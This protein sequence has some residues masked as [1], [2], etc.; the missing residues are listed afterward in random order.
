MVFNVTGVLLGI[1]PSGASR[2]PVHTLSIPRGSHWQIELLVTDEEGTPINLTGR[3]VAIGVKAA[4]GGASLVERAAVL[5]DPLNGICTVYGT[6]TD[7]ESLSVTTYRWD[8]WVDD[9]DGRHQIV[10][11]SNF[12]VL[13]AILLPDEDP[14]PATPLAPMINGF[15][16]DLD[17]LAL[18][19]A[20]RLGPGFELWVVSEGAY[21]QVRV[22]EDFDDA[23]PA[24]NLDGGQWIP[25][26]AGGTDSVVVEVPGEWTQLCETANAEE[27]IDDPRRVDFDNELSASVQELVATLLAY[28]KVTTGTGRIRVRRAGTLGAADG[29]VIADGTLTGTSYAAIAPTAAAFARPSGIQVLQVT[30]SNN[31][32]GAV[33]SLKGIRLGLR[34]E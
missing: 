10:K 32:V 34:A 8:G 23:V 27:V 15:V 3:A 25:V 16:A 4:S 31:T 33:T 24:L 11:A 18:V 14:S 1:A 30:V 19:E 13:E 5:T 12:V 17:A 29:T 7:T 21:Y 9:D 2:P 22:D 20:S 26:A 6:P 28:A